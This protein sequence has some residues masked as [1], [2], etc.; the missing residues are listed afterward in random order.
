MLMCVFAHSCFIK[1]P[2]VGSWETNPCFFRGVCH[3]GDHENE[4]ADLE[5]LVG[6]P[7]G[8]LR[9]CHKKKAPLDTSLLHHS[10]RLEKINKGFNPSSASQSVSS[11]AQGQSSRNTKEKGKKPMM[12]EDPL[13]EGHSVPGAPPAPHLSSQCSSDRQWVL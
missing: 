13:Y 3:T 12:V 6:K 8:F 11:N 9:R 10:T 2:S 5:M 7:L 1:N 4:E